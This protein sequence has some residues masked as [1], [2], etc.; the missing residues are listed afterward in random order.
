MN[1]RLP[2]EMTSFIRNILGTLLMLGN[3]PNQHFYPDILQVFWSSF[4][5]EHD[6]PFP[7]SNICYDSNPYSNE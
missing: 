7:L 4:L 1:A 5:K 6:T 3:E 2:K